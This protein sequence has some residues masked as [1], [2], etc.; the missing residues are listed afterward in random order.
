MTEP[1]SRDKPFDISKW[2]V[3]EAFQ[4]VKANKGA[5]GVDEVSIAEFEQDRDKNLYRILESYVVGKLLPTSGQSGGDSQS[6][7]D[8]RAGARGA[9]CGGSGR[10]DGGQDVSGAKS[11]TD[12]PSGLL[13]LSAEEVRVGRRRHLSAALLEG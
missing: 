9:D 3:W 10:A 6:W 2:V 1:K 11:R 4:R 8:G 5:A 12:L 7:R 13:R